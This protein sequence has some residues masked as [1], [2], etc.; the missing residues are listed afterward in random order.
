MSMRRHHQ[1]GGERNG[2]KHGRRTELDPRAVHQGVLRTGRKSRCNKPESGSL[3]E[4][5]RFKRGLRAC[6][7]EANKFC[8]QGAF[9]TRAALLWL[10]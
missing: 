7:K 9:A 6:C 1:A 3:G 5:Y 8:Q 2:G 4:V 10:P